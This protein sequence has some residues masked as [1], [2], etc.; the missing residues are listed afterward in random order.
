MKRYQVAIN[1]R[2]LPGQD[3]E[4][5]RQ[6]LCRLFRL[7]EEGGKRFFNGRT[8][9]VKN[10]LDRK[11]AEI[12]RQTIEKTGAECVILAQQQGPVAGQA[13][14]SSA[15]NF[16]P[17]CGARLSS[18]GTPRATNHRSGECPSCGIVIAK[19]LR[20]QTAGAPESPRN[21]KEQQPSQPKEHLP[22]SDSNPSEQKIDGEQEAL[23]PAPLSRRFLA[24]LY[25]VLYTAS[26]FLPVYVVAVVL[27]YLSTRWRLGNAS[28][29]DIYTILSSTNRQHDFVRGLILIVVA[30][31]SLVVVPFRQQQTWGQQHQALRLVDEAGHRV[32]NEI[33]YWL[34]GAATVLVY[35]SCGLLALVPFFNKR[36]R[37]LADLF[38]R[39]HLATDHNHQ[40]QTFTGMAIIAC[41]LLLLCW[42]AQFGMKNSLDQVVMQ[43][44]NPPAATRAMQNSQQ[45]VGPVNRSRVQ[46]QLKI[47]VLSQRC[48]DG[49][50]E[51]CQLLDQATNRK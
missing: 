37:S 24:S 21:G 30:G 3:P 7:S 43:K 20:Q 32:A 9:V 14:P 1:A 5:V 19:F 44:L 35:V 29:E 16:C 45:Q 33:V 49:E 6:R 10:D 2:P 13:A 36:R 15:V 25:T 34:R 28:I 46:D 39:T 51:A 4:Q 11:Q 42:A 50:E 38:S 18:T 12:I 22:P 41:S 27:I 47:T 26:I 23:S 31:L 8:V 17:K 48:Q 40:P